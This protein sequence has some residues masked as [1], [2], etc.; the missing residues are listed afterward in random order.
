MSRWGGPPREGDVDDRPVRRGPP[1]VGSGFE[2]VRER[3][4]HKLQDTG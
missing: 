2:G 1:G 4:A 3:S